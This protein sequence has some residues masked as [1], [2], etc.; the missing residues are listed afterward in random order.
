MKIAVVTRMLRK[1]KLEG[2][3]VFTHEILSRLV[4]EHPEHEFLF[5]F[6][7]KYDHQFIYTE[8][9]KPFILLPP[10]SHPRLLVFWYQYRLRW[11]LEKH[12]PDLL[13]SPD[14]GIPL[15]TKTKTLAVIHDLNFEHFPED[16][17]DGVLHYYQY[18][19]RRIAYQATRLIT[20]SEFSKEDIQV[21]YKVSPDKIDVIYNGVGNQFARLGENEIAATRKKYAESLPYF[22]FVGSIHQRKNLPNM[23]KAFTEFRKSNSPEM[24]F[25]IAGAKRWWN[26]DMENAYE[27]SA[28]KKDI[29]FIGRVNDNELPKLIGSAHALLFASRFEGFGIPIIEAMQCGVPVITSNTSSMPEVA[30]DAGVLVNPDSIDSICDAMKKMCADEKLRTTCVERGIVRAKAFSWDQSA[31]LFWKSVEKTISG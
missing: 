3:G 14:G 24:K 21:K 5:L 12:K 18:Y 15:E 29:L 6:D 26:D 1:D 9:V 17:P 11:F 10:A 8:K 28:F 13:I 16:M 25:V 31:R 2:F 20:V 23:M 7:R 19:Y 30:G 27:K 22:L 4:K